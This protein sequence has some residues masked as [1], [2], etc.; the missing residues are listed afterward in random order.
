MKAPF[1]E[2]DCG[3]RALARNAV[4]TNTNHTLEVAHL[5]SDVDVPTLLLWGGDDVLV[6][7]EWADRIAADLPNAEQE[8]L[9]DAYHWVMQNRP[10]AYRTALEGFLD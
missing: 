5:I 3:P 8:Y 6:S 1:P 10:E 9:D 2:R 4:S 7:T